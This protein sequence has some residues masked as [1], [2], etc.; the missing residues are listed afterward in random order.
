MYKKFIKKIITSITSVS[1]IASNLFTGSSFATQID[2]TADISYQDS[3]NV[4][5]ILKSNLQTTNVI[6]TNLGVSDNVTD[7]IKDGV[8]GGTWIFPASKKH[9]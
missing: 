7:K 8:S 4:T 3:K 5:Y 6:N 1:L 9:W 2:N